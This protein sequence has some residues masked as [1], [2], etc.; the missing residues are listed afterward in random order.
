MIEVEEVKR[1]DEVQV[2]DGYWIVKFLF[3]RDKGKL[4]TIFRGKYSNSRV[5]EPIYVPKA[6][7][8]AFVR[9]AYA[10]FYN[11]R[12]KKVVVKPVNSAQ[13]SLGI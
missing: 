12:K 1:T 8:A 9:K 7:Y 3:D 4:K 6:I 11:S 5:Y 2:T 10:V 13:L